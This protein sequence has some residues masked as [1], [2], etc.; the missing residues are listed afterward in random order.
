MGIEEIKEIKEILSR[1]YVFNGDLFT[2]LV[3]Y[4]QILIFV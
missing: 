4:L 1:T 2:F 3:L